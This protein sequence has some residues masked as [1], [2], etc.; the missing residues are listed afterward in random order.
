M[1][2]ERGQIEHYI[3]GQKK[4]GLTNKL[5]TIFCEFDPFLVKPVES[6][7][8]GYEMSLSDGNFVL[9][10]VAGDLNN[11]HSITER[12][13]YRG[14]AVRSGDEQDLREYRIIG[15]TF[16]L[17]K[18]IRNQGRRSYLGEIKLNVQ[19][20]VH[21]SGILLWI[22]DLEESSGW[23]TMKSLGLKNREEKEMYLAPSYH[24]IYSVIEI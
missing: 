18:T 20:V 13:R 9:L 15:T 3:K 22:Q 8:F 6:H 1:K 11:F 2:L 10:C 4:F 14:Q 7:L 24:F 16:A 17:K 5:D 21:K 12:S 19:I 23:V